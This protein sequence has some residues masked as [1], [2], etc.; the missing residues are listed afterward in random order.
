MDDDTRSELALFKFSII[1]PLVTGQ[2]EGSQ[3]KYL[4]Q[5][6][7]KTYTVP[8][9]GE[10][11]FS[12]STIKHWLYDYRRHGLDGLK[13]KPRTDQGN[14]RSITP[15][16]KS[17][18]SE[19]LKAEPER[20]AVNIYRDLLEAN[21]QL[22]SL[23]TVSRFIRK[24]RNTLVTSD[25]ER[26][27]FE[28]A[29]ANDCWQSDVLAGPYLTLKGRKKKTYLIAFLDDASRLLLYA[30]FYFTE[31]YL[32][33]ENTLRQALLKRGL[34]KKLFVDNGKIFHSK[35][36]RLICGRLGIALSHARPY[37]PASRGK[38]ERW[39]RTFRQG[40]LSRFRSEEVKTLA[41]LNRLG[42]SFSEQYNQT[43]HSTLGMSPMERFMRDES[44]LRF[45]SPE[46]LNHAFL[47]E[48]N[49]R[50]TKDA[51]ISLKNIIFE[52]PSFYA[53]QQVKVLFNPHNLK[54]AFLASHE[55]E[56]ITIKPVQ[57]VD[58]SKIPRKQYIDQLDY[59]KLF[60]GGER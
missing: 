24:Q 34:P 10:K 50:A 8:G 28:F 1:A 39:F 23:S 16:V 44:L 52:V 45:V 19:L 12:P 15:E 41:E 4:E 30:E 11:E 43:E 48:V 7:S 33:L 42:R 21:M 5:V 29:H 13:R 9:I 6:A 17:V 53:G 31:N 54:E 3:Q 38:I 26:R 20:T 14:F 49:R 35:Q 36:L 58:N 60:E 32:A 27:R 40:C 47:H 56:L 46:E 59:T 2:I 25:M 57:L 51:T 18:I 37:S 55:G 22:P